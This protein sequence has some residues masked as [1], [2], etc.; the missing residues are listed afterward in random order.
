MIIT[1]KK[2][3]KYREM[4]E[5]IMGTQQHMLSKGLHLEM[6]DKATKM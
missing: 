1:V 3:E 2:Q 5:Q 4:A 6:R